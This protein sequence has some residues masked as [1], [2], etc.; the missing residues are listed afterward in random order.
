MNKDSLIYVAGHLGLVGS[1]VLRKLISEGYK[2]II[3]RT[4]TELDLREQIEVNLFFSKNKPEYVFICAGQVGGIMANNTRRGEF[5]YDNMMIQFN[6]IHAAHLYKSKKLLGLGSACI[7]PRKNEG[8]ILENKLLTG[9]LEPTN[10]PYAISKIAA[11]KMCDAYR[12][13]YGCNFISAMPCNMYGVCDS[14]D[15]IKSHVPAALIRKFIV[16]KRDNT[17]VT[18]WGTGTPRREFL[19]VDD[20]A[21]ACLFLMNNYNES[22]H[23]NIGTGVDI[24]LNEL[25][26]LIA[27]IIGFKGEIVHDTSKPDGMPRRRLDVSKINN[28]GWSAKIDLREGL[29]ITIENIYKTGKHLEW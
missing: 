22:G 6:V 18:I 11:L 2:N 15:P 16:A 23:V 8:A 29:K 28:M 7:Y 12:H 26:A 4:T 5:I 3:T 20:M 10:E 19:Y 21:D 24:E 27:D 25:A 14:Y 1:A 17:D 9:E 13:Q